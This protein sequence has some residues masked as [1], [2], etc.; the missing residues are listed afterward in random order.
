MLLPYFG[1]PGGWT[2][3][4]RQ[5]S[6]GGPA[7]LAARYKFQ[8]TRISTKKLTECTSFTFFLV[9]LKKE[10]PVRSQTFEKIVRRSHQRRPPLTDIFIDFT[11]WKEKLSQVR[12]YRHFLYR[13]QAPIRSDDDATQKLPRRAPHWWYILPK[14]HHQCWTCSLLGSQLSLGGCWNASL[15]LGFLL[16]VF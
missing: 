1:W 13:F 6:T 7:T 8:K 14:G 16:P 11:F 15:R 9:R 12:P 5:E 2:W 10:S 4:I 3:W